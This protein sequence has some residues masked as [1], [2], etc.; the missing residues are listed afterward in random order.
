MWLGGPWRIASDRLTSMRETQACG[1]V[2]SSAVGSDKGRSGV[3]SAK[4]TPQA[5]EKGVHNAADTADK[6]GSNDNT[7][8]VESTG[9]EGKAEPKK[10]A[11]SGKRPLG[12]KEVIPF[13]WK[14]VGLSH[15]VALTLFKAVERTDVEAQYE[16]VK[17]EGYYTDLRILDINEKVKQ[18][19][20]LRPPKPVRATATR[21]AAK[22]TKGAK[23]ASA[24]APAKRK[25]AE[26]EATAGTARASVKKIRKKK[27][28]TKAVKK[29]KAAPPKTTRKKAKKRS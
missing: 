3:S 22:S 5:E 13:A 15:D 25:R 4:K 2:G 19:K 18:P 17:R 26:E 10:P 9:S 1:L 28:A 12:T 14:L 16:R 21:R 29:K 27:V 7:E 23:R 6:P 20:P 11:S 24:K 8:P